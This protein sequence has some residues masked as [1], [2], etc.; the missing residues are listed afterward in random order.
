[1]FGKKKE[2]EAPRATARTEEPAA[3]PAPKVETPA[4]LRPQP[5]MAATEL[6]R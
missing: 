4:V 3:K 2:V 1:M 6:P 5:A